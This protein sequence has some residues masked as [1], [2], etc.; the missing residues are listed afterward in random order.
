MKG[1]RAFAMMA[2]HHHHHDDRL[3][4]WLAAGD[5]VQEEL[6]RRDPGRCFRPPYV[7]ARGRLGVVLDG[8]PDRG[9]TEGLVVEAWA[10]AAP[11]RLRRALRRGGGA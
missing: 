8:G 6:C 7:G 10:V 5:G 11:P 2:D 9:E 4:V 1:G 3:A